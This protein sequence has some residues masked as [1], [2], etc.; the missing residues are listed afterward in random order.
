[1]GEPKWG[2]VIGAERRGHC[3]NSRPTQRPRSRKS[4]RAEV[5]G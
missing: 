4:K 2:L 3:I 5:E 1:M